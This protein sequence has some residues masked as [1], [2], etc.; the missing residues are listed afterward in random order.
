MAQPTQ[1]TVGLF[2]RPGKP[3]REAERRATCRDG[4]DD[5]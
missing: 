3:A 5:G 4:L 2:R 1:E